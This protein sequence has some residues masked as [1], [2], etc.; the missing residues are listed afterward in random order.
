M[1]QRWTL[2]IENF[3]R[4]KEAA[5]EIRP[6]T[7]FVGENNSGKSYVATLLWGIWAFAPSLFSKRIPTS[8]D[9]LEC[10]AVI[11][12]LAK[13]LASNPEE[14]LELTEQQ[15]TVFIGWF[16]TILN[17]KRQELVSKTFSTDEIAIGKLTIIDYKRLSPFK[18]KVDDNLEKP[19]H[20]EE[21]LLTVSENF[22][23]SINDSS[24]DVG[25]FIYETIQDL[26]LSLLFFAYPNVSNHHS[27]KLFN[28]FMSL[29]IRP[30]KKAPLFLPTSRT[31]FMHTFPA[32]VADAL[33][34]DGLKLTAPVRRFL[35]LLAQPK[36]KANADTKLAA[37]AE[38]LEH[39]LIKGKIEKLET[40]SLPI[41]QYKADKLAAIPMYL[42]SSLVSEVAPLVHFLRSF[43]SYNALFI[44]EPEAHLHP[45]AQ[46]TMARALARIMNQGVPVLTTTHGDTLFQ[47]LNN[48]AV[49][50]SHPNKKALLKELNYNK[51][52]L[53]NP[54][55]MVAYQFKRESGQTLVERLDASEYGIAVPTFNDPLE[56]LLDEIYTIQESD[57]DNTD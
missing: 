3:A 16:N 51:D 22:I 32:L 23:K 39:E 25:N 12:Q 43:N 38:W 54:N 45:A 6:L 52:E 49:L 10:K 30:P 5:I 18:I 4:I 27:L 29:N 47:Q 48:L 9:Y 28:L 13:T 55:D 24:E 36:N 1:Q 2:Q 17:R 35:Q 33:S 46:R 56:E 20:F 14:A 21:S 7:L 11:K 15:Q 31:S 44:E 42:T 40:E 41:Y 8:A 34:G 57:E 19:F 53:I 37:I 50:Y 26:I